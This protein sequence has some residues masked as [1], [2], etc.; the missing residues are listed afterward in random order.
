MEKLG[1]TRTS[2]CAGRKNRS[3]DQESREYQYELTL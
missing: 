2:E 3:S 1:M